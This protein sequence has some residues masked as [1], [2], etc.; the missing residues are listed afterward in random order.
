MKHPW[1]DFAGFRYNN[2]WRDTHKKWLFG[3]YK[4]KNYSPFNKAFNKVTLK[5]VSSVNYNYKYLK[6][7]P[8]YGKYYEE[9]KVHCWVPPLTNLPPRDYS[10]RYDGF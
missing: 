2:S 1:R 10:I 9:Y 8:R 4:S 6:N 3:K 5:E 7:N